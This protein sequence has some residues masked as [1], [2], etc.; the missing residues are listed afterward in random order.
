AVSA[1]PSAPVLLPVD[2]T[3]IAIGAAGALL[4]GPDERRPV[5]SDRQTFPGAGPGHLL[6]DHDGTVIAIA[7]APG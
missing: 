2:G 6:M 7:G 1:D 3:L 5:R 4:T